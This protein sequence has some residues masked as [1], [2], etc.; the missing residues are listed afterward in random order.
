MQRLLQAIK[1]VSQHFGREEPKFLGLLASKFDRR[2]P[3]ERVLFEG[4][5]DEIGA[6]LFPGLVAKRDVYARAASERIADSDDPGQRFR[7]KPDAESDP[8]RTVIP[9]IP[10]KV[11]VD[12]V[13]GS[14]GRLGVKH[15]RLGGPF[16]E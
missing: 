7:L 2:S 14:G 13:M 5:A 1:G 8:R 4:L 15:D 12:V 11:V 6:L 3:R 16:A 10:S 9:M